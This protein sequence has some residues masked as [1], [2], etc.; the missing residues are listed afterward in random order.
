MKLAAIS[1]VTGDKGSCLIYDLSVLQSYE[2]IGQKINHIDFGRQCQLIPNNEV[3]CQAGMSCRPRQKQKSP[4]QITPWSAFYSIFPHGRD[5]Q[6]PC[7][8]PW[9]L[10]DQGPQG[11]FVLGMQETGL[12]TALCGAIVE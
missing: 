6:C 12:K 7:S 11:L 3:K 10:A 1:G 2:G 4:K 9:D 8:T 5:S